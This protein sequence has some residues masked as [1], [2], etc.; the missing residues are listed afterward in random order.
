M[1][2]HS[3]RSSIGS[4]QLSK[5]DD[6]ITE[7][8]AKQIIETVKLELRDPAKLSRRPSRTSTFPR[9]RQLEALSYRDVGKAEEDGE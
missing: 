1:S 3:L 2:H 5:G 4:P 7:I 9:P 8:I 6:P